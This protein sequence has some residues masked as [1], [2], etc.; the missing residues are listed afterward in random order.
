MSQA[1]QILKSRFGF[2]AF[3]L[4]QQ[5]IIDTVLRKKDTVVLMPT[6]GGKS[7]CYQIPAL[8]FPGLT[9]V[10][11]PLIALMKDQV[12]ALQLNGIPAAFIN[13]TQTDDEQAEVITLMREGRLRLLYLA[14]ERFFSQEGQ[15]IELLRSVQVSLF[16]V[17]E[18]HCISQW[19]HDFR[20]EYLRL[21]ALK[22][23]FP[24]VPVIALTATADPLTRKDILDKL[25]LNS[26][27]VFISSFDRKNIHYFVE[28]K[29]GAHE[30][31][32]AYLAAHRDDSGIIYALSRQSVDDLAAR[33]ER[34]GFSAK[35]YHAGLDKEVREAHQDLFIE[36]KVKIMVATIAFGMGIDKSNVR[37]VIHMDMPKNIEGYYQET[38]RAGRDGLKSEAILF[39]GQ[40]DVIKLKKFTQVEGNPEQTEILLK[41]LNQMARFCE[42]RTSCRRKYLLNY[43]G[44]DHP[45]NCGACDACL[46][47][48]DKVDGTEKAR[49][50]LTA[51]AAL[52]GRFGVNYMID[53]LRGSKSGKIK[54]YHL[55]MEGY[56]AGASTGKDEWRQLFYQ[57]M[58]DGYLEQQGSQYPTVR[59]TSK[60]AAVLK[61]EERVILI[62]F[63]MREQA[64]P[65]AAPHE[66]GLLTALKKLRMDL[67]REA[68]VPAYVIFSDA[69]LLELAT[70]LPQSSE[71]LE[72]VAGFGQMK[73]ARYGAV[74]LD[75]VRGFC[76]ERGLVSRM[77]EKPGKKSPKKKP[78]PAAGASAT[79][80]ETLRLFKSGRTSGQ[81]AEARALNLA[82]VEGHLADFVLDGT[83][84]VRELVS[85]EKLARISEAVHR[86]GFGWLG[87][88]KNALGEQVTFGQIR[89]VMNHIKFNKDYAK[90]AEGR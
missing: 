4:E 69:T 50:A 14:P 12:N 39:Y 87:P 57:L 67:A 13:S 43:F 63:V 76:R 62:K 86:I 54:E 44:E 28:P 3:R 37:Y 48:Y 81:I 16:A 33:L 21:A 75:A 74:F 83:L 31:L 84:D 60:S 42:A 10:I 19:G 18:A 15:F 41:K 32:L 34:E 7:I 2:D 90:A 8:L 24:G 66:E 79:K 5:N 72:R 17:D 82:T 88:I 45:G 70:Y 77:G 35:P 78:A 55:G 29:R 73:L 30:R 58:E 68:S 38:G 6:G 40:G 64:T 80:L 51:V 85:E 23:H 52:R 56:G 9:V 46:T 1:Q 20:P 22:R 27:T 59:L 47:Q 65:T 89:A 26:P 49:Q 25:N 61:G 11:S 36:D 53:F 71:E